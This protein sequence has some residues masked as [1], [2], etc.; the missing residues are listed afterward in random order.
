M[1]DPVETDS[2]RLLQRLRAALAEGG[3]GQGRLDPDHRADRRIDGDRCVLHLSDAR[4]R[5]AGAL[6]DAGLNAD[7]VHQTRMRVGEGLVGRIA[8]EARPL[9]TGDAPGTRG[10]RYMPETGEEVYSAFL[11]VPI[12]RLGQTLGVLV[13]QSR[14]KQRYSGDAVYA[15]EVV[16]M[17]IAEM[18]E[19]GAFVGEGEALRAPHKRPV[20]LRG[21][22]AQDG[23]ATGQVFLHEPRRR[24]HQ[25][26][27]RRSRPRTAAP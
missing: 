17:V 1:T 2:R 24:H 6:R 23:V 20:L 13:V 3:G 11:G 7:A 15:L 26:D 9:N 21:V 8:R 19:L 10:F 27:R 14:G 16:A 18:A 12:Q 4:P 5:Y 25:P 22:G